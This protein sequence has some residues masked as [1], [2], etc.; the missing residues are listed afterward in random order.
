MLPF[1]ALL[2]AIF[3]VR[4]RNRRINAFRRRGLQ[5]QRAL[6]IVLA[7]FELIASL[8][9]LIL[10][11]KISLP[12]PSELYIVSIIIG[13]SALLIVIITN[14]FLRYLK[15]ESNT[16]SMI[17]SS[18]AMAAVLLGGYFC[19]QENILNVYQTESVFDSNAKAHT[20]NLQP[21]SIGF[22]REK[23]PKFLFCMEEEISYGIPSLPAVENGLH[24]CLGER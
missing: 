6:F 2:I 11:S 20:V 9:F 10:R 17:I 4:I 3:V 21:E 24:V 13:I 18:I 7:L 23:D 15:L 14:K 1:Y 16:N 22:S 12:F 5:I 8:A 19:W